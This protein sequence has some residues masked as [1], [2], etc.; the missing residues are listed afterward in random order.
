MAKTFAMLAAAL[1]LMASVGATMS[2]D[3]K[4]AR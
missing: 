3:A 4:A 2:S 1:G